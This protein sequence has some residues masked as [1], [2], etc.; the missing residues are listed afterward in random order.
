MG[1]NEIMSQ[2]PCRRYI[3]GLSL[4]GCMATFWRFDR[5]SILISE[6]FN[7]QEVRFDIQ[8]L[9]QTEQS[10]RTDTALFDSYDIVP[11]FRKK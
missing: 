8:I 3:Y 9:L 2:N 7:F 6:T 4:D 10:S 11:R 1:A 5:L